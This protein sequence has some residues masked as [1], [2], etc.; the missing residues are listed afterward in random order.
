L[1]LQFARVNNVAFFAFFDDLA[2]VSVSWRNALLFELLG[3]FATKAGFFFGVNAAT[4]FLHIEASSAGFVLPFAPT[5]TEVTIKEFNAIFFGKLLHK[6]G[7]FVVLLV[8]A[9]KQSRS[10]CIVAVSLGILEGF[11]KTLWIAI[12][13]TAFI[14]TIL[15]NLTD[16]LIE[17]IGVFEYEL[18]PLLLCVINEAVATSL[19]FRI[20]MDVWVIPEK[21]RLDIFGA[22]RFNAVD[23][24]WRAT[25]ME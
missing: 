11:A 18:D 1:F 3:N 8:D 16:K 19:I 7:N 21:C 20:R 24:A 17:A 5:F 6:F 22:Q 12:L 2:N 13:L 4:V 9:I 15:I 23:T 10:D 25:S 14:K